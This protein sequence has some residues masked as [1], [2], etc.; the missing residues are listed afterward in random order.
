MD[1]VAILVPVLDR[2]ERVQPFLD[3]LAASLTP[4]R[5]TVV[6]LVDENDGNEFLAVDAQPR[7]VAVPVAA[8]M[9]YAAKINHGYHLTDDP[10]IFQ[11]ADDLAF[12]PGW[13]DYA[14]W[15]AEQTGAAVIGTNDLCNQRTM[16]GAHSTHS[17]VRRSYLDE[18]GGVIDE[19]PGS[20]MHES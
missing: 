16:I 17:L 8:G 20:F 4:D 7:G 12:H 18:V 13:L 3:S 14:L 11:A 9:S 19:G 6:F 15:R 10:W 2:P 1:P 5:Y